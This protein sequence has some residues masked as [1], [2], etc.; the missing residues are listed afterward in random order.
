MAARFDGYFLYDEDDGV[1][2][3]PL[4]VRITRVS[5]GLGVVPTDGSLSHMIDHTLLK[6]DAT[7]A[8]NARA[9]ANWL[10]SATYLSG[11]PNVVCFD[12]FDRNPPAAEL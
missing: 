5:D 9:F 12:L 1:D 10:K 3:G 8:D 7:E 11:H 2:L 6:P 4:D